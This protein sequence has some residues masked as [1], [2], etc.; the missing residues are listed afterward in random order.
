MHGVAAK[1]RHPDAAKAI[2]PL[3]TIFSYFLTFLC[4][5]MLFN[6]CCNAVLVRRDWR[7]AR[8]T[9]LPRP[10][11]RVSVIVP[12]RNEALNIE[13]C[14]ESLGAQQYPD[15]EVICIDDCSED[16]T[17]PIARGVAERYPAVRV[18]E[19]APLP[20]GWIGKP[21]ACKQGFDAA[22]G[23]FLLFTDADTEFHPRALE[24]AVRYAQASEAGLLSGLPRLVAVSLWERLSVPI[25][26][27]TTATFVYALISVPWLRRLSAASGAF[28]F[29]R[30]EVYEAIGGHERVRGNI[31]DDLGLARATK[32][33]GHRVVMTEVAGLVRCRMYRSFAEIWEG[34][35][36]NFSKV[37][38]GPTILVPIVMMMILFWGPWVC[39]VAAALSGEAMLVPA[40][41]V[42]CVLG[43]RCW[44]DERLGTRDYLGALLSPVAGVFFS[45][46][47]LRSWSRALLKQPTPWRNRTYELW[48]EE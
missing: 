29:F 39:L 8:G 24:Q 21:W 27:F 33:D 6:A 43:V 2:H 7:R 41:Q 14:L 30:R 16:G 38:P 42:L 12:A 28:L 19:G 47:A 48:K 20:Q 44:S 35:S 25:L 3:V 4:C 23:E 1:Y 26:A 18:I 13:A 36:K 15:F 46:I 11:P 5:G 37:F 45:V 31:V 32:W 17:G 40:L 22:T 9:A 34:F 10:A